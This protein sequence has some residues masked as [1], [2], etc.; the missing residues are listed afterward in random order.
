MK[1]TDNMRELTLEEMIALD[2]S[3]DAIIEKLNGKLKARTENK[4]NTIQT[5]A[6][7]KVANAIKEY[8]IALG[9]PAAQIDEIVLDQVF[10]SFEK[11]IEPAV[12]ILNK[13]PKEK[14]NRISLDEDALESA[15]GA[16]RAFADSI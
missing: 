11:E 9:V 13:V 2:Y 10:E 8:L 14:K 16:L 12:K 3:D 4:K 6:R 1:N 7:K 5:A 15:L